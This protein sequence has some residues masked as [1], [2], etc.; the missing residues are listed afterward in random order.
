MASTDSQLREMLQS[1]DL[2]REI[3]E[4]EVEV[5]VAG[6]QKR[7]YSRG[8]LIFAKNDAGTGVKFVESGRVKI[9]SVSPAGTEV[10]LNIIESGQVF[11]E[12]ALLDGNP[13]SADAIAATETTLISLSR[14]SFL[15][16]LARNPG[17]A[18]RMMAIL[19]GR[20]R[21]AT[22]FVEDAVLLDAQTRLVHRLKAL[23][24]QYGKVEADGLAIRVEHGLSQ[25]ELGESVGLT[26]VS[27]N[28]LLSQLRDRGLITDG[29]GFV[30]IRDMKAL[31]DEVR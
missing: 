16:V 14:K 2:M 11:G 30:V 19:C 17:I 3:P 25:Q 15:D 26:H 9:V 7:Q 4:H 13:R 18:T 8:Q 21:Q 20:I 29:R 23:A 6:V 24:G 31:E 12:M 10:I 5:L 22:S 28:R 1:S 27:I